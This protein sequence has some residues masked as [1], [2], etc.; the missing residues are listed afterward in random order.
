MGVVADTHAAVWYL[1]NDPRLSK[2]AGFAL[3]QSTASGHR[4][5]I[6][7]ISLVELTYLIEK[8]R[9]PA[10]SRSR[11]VNAIADPAGPY[12]LA[13]LDAAVA[14]AVQRVDRSIRDLPDRVIAATALAW[15]MPLVSRDGKIRASQIETIW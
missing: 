7:S 11:L 13:P 6:P 9:L 10:A 1:A 4:I 14:E 12:R 2:A 15:N 8:G 3:D 5:L